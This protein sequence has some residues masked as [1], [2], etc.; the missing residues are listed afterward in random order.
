MGLFQK[1]KDTT[2][3]E[4]TPEFLATAFAAMGSHQQVRFFEQ[5]AKETAMWAEAEKETDRLVN[6]IHPYGAMQWCHMARD[7][8]KPGNEEALKQYRALAAFAF[9]Y[10]PEKGGY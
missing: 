10:W 2:T 3:V 8:E 1:V 6:Q 9:E 7:L 4:V 5:L